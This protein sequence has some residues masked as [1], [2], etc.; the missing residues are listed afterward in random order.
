MSTKKNRILIVDD[1]SVIREILKGILSSNGYVVDEAENGLKALSMVESNIYDHV[2]TDVSMPEMDGLTFLKK[3]REKGIDVSVT[4]VSAYAEMDNVVEAIKAGASDF[5]AKPF[6]SE[7]QILFTLKKIEERDRLQREN[8]LLRKEI[9]HQYTFS[10]IVAKSQKMKAIF[11]IIAKIA[12]YKTTVLITGDSGTGKELIAKAIHYNSNRRNMPLVSINCGG[13]PE[14]L[15]ESELFGHEKGAFTD[16]YRSK[17]GLF[18]EADGGTLFLDEIGE[19]SMPLQVKLLRALQEEEIRPLGGSKQITVDVRIIAATAKNLRD[20]V[21]NGRFREDLFYRINVLTIDVPP[22]RNR[23]EDIP[24]LIEHFIKKY[25]ERL[26]AQI[27]RVDADFLQALMEYSWPGNVRELENIIERSMA[28]A[29]TNILTR[30]N[31][32]CELQ[33][34]KGRKAPGFPG[35]SLSIKENKKYFE[36]D[37]IKSALAETKNN[38]TRAAALLEISIPALLYKMKDY[39]IQ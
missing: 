15:L 1:D 34:E 18:E 23:R 4:V 37:L 3:L 13:I 21:D 22:L 27:E 12:D 31:L 7:D 20:E 16:A 25:N 17:K 6:Q 39:G 2:V 9:E 28:L 5:I 8:T 14:T 30:E 26:S 11:D 33:R 38:R 19:L 32:S 24:L 36:A 29:N 10:N 35:E